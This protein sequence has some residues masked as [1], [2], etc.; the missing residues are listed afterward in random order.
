L[1][2]CDAVLLFYGAGDEAWKRTKDN[3]LKKMAGYRAGRPLL[4]RHT[5]LAPPRTSDKDDLIDTEEPDLINGLETFSESAM[6]AMVRTL[7]ASGTPR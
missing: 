3:E 1:T 2:T 6:A 7:K 4:A 5:Y